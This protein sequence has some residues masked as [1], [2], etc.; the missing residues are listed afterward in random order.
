MYYFQKGCPSWYEGYQFGSGPTLRD[1]N[2]FLKKYNFNINSIKF[3]RSRPFTINQQL[4]MIFPSKL[5]YLIPD[6]SLLRLP[7]FK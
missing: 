6:N 4:M 2:I 3:E 5:S 7:P 1:L